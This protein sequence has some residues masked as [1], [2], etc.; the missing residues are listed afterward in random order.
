[1][2]TKDRIF[3]MVLIALLLISI[4]CMVHSCT[5]CQKSLNEL[6]EVIENE[7]PIIKVY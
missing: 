7:I 6:N 4:V 2:K 1:M 3:D 5:E